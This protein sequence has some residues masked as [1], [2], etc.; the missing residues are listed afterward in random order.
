MPISE[1]QQ[2]HLRQLPAV[3][4]LI[5]LSQN[6]PALAAIPKTVLVR[7]IRETIESKRRQIM[8]ADAAFNPDHLRSDHLIPQ[9]I[10]RVAKLQAYNL[11]RTINATGVVVHTNSD[12][13]SLPSSGKRRVTARWVSSW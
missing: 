5:G 6:E 10:R 11:K 4:L 13:F 12:S 9:V 3:D 1:Q 2:H 8:E 7:A